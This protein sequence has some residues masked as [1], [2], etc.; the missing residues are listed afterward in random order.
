MLKLVLWTCTVLVLALVLLLTVNFLT[1][2]VGWKNAPV[3]GYGAAVFTVMSLDWLR[4]V[5]MD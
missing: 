4:R 3:I 5:V 1:A 2:S